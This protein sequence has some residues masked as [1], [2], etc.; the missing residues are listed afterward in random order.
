VLIIG[1]GNPARGDDGLGPACLEALE[2]AR[3]AGLLADCFDT[4]TDFQLQVELALDL[5]GYDELVFV[6]AHLDLPEACEFSVITPAQDHSFSSHALSPAA[7]LAAYAQFYNAAPPRAYQLAIQGKA[8]ALGEPL[9]MAAKLNLQE[10]LTLLQS[11]LD[12][13]LHQ[14]RD[15]SQAL[16]CALTMGR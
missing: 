15:A 2:Q 4:L 16:P 12:S 10:A 6:D 7:L 1:Y 14:T 13:Y 8:F 9:S 11:H 5:H 3:D